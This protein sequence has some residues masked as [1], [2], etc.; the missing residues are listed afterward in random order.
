MGPMTAPAIQALSDFGAG[1][2][3]GV[4]VDGIGA[5]KVRVDAVRVEPLDTVGKVAVD[6]VNVRRWPNTCTIY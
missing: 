6:L 4:G 3:V 5:D 2:R 1:A